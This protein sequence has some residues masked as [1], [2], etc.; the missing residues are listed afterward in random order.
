MRNPLNSI[1]N[2]CKIVFSVCLNFKKLITTYSAYIDPQ[3]HEKLNEIHDHVL[4]GNEI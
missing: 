2:Q 3:V 1:I 4:K